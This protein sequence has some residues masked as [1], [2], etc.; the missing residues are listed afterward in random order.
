[1]LRRGAQERVLKRGYS[2]ECT[3]ERKH[4]WA[5]KKELRR[6]LN[7]S[8][9]AGM[10]ADMQAGMQAGMQASKQERK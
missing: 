5:I 8:I 10:Q 3:Q 7:S 6:V 9:L 4:L 2:R 1:M